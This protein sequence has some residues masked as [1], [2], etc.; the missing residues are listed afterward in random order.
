MAEK[1]VDTKE[2]LLAQSYDR[3]LS[4]NANAGSGK[5]T[6]LQKRFVALLLDNNLKV[7]PR[8]LVA[9][10]F[11]RKAAAEI[12]A[13]IAKSIEEIIQDSLISKTQHTK[14]IRIRE[15]LNSA[16]ISTIHSFC[17]SLIRDFPIES[18]VP[19]NF[20]ELS[21]AEKIGIMKD[22]ITDT[23]TDYLTSNDDNTEMLKLL[24]SAFGKKKVESMIKII[25]Y[26]RDVLPKI[27]LFYETHTDEEI[28]QIAVL[29]FLKYLSDNY[30]DTLSEVYRIFGTLSKLNLSR[31]QLTLIIAFRNIIN[32]VINLLNN[33]D[34]NINYEDCFNFNLSE[35]CDELNK[36][37]IL[38]Q[39]YLLNSPTFK[40]ILND[41]LFIYNAELENLQE[42]IK[43]LSC[44]DKIN[45]QTD[46]ISYARFLFDLT[47][48]VNEI[49]EYK[50]QE[51]G[52]LDFD[53][54]LIKAQD[55]LQNK[56]VAEKISKRF[57]FMM[58]DEFQDT[59]EIQYKIIKSLVPQLLDN[60]LSEQINL[61]IVGDPKQ[62][63][64]G[65]RNA[66]VRVFK[67]ATEDIRNCNQSLIQNT[68]L[69]KEINTA[70]GCISVEDAVQSQ[71]E[72]GLTVSFRHLPVITA[73]TNLICGNVMNR[74]D[75][76][77]DVEYS[78]LVCSKRIPELNNFLCSPNLPGNLEEDQFGSVR[79]LVCEK[80]DKEKKD[81]RISEAELLAIYI[82][83]FTATSQYKFSDI[84][85]LS[86]A[87]TKFNE[88][89]NAFQKYN[90]PYVLHSGKGFYQAQEVIDMIS[91][92]KFLHNPGD[93]LSI[94][95]ALRS[96]YFGLTDAQILQISSL[97]QKSLFEK[98]EYIVKNGHSTETVIIRS[99]EIISK[100]LSY[101]TRLS[102]SHLIAQTVE[103]CGWF[104]TSASSSG[105]AQVTANLLKLKQF[106]SDF[107]KRGFKTLFDFVEEVNLISK[108]EITESEAAF[109]TD[110]NAVNFLTIHAAK[111]LEFPVVA[112]FNNNTG[113]N[114]GDSFVIDE[115]LGLSFN[116]P[117]YNQELQIYQEIDTP[118]F[119]FAK[120]KNILKEKAELKRLLYVA[121][122]RAKEHL[123]IT[124]DLNSTKH[125][126]SLFE[127]ILQGLLI[128][129]GLLQA[130]EMQFLFDLQIYLDGTIDTHMI[131]FKIDIIN[132]IELA[133]TDI[134]SHTIQQPFPELLMD[135]IKSEISNDMFSASRIIK[136]REDR[137]A[138]FSRYVLG[139]D[140][141]FTL[142]QA[143]DDMSKF[144]ID[145]SQ[146]TIDE[147]ILRQAQ[148]DLDEGRL[149]AADRRQDLI[150]N[151]QFLITNEKDSISSAE[152]GTIIHF[153]MENIS[154][155]C[156]E[157]IINKNVLNDL[158]EES[159][160]IIRKELNNE[161][162]DRI[163]QEISNMV[164]T[165]L[166]KKNINEIISSKH[167]AEYNIPI[168]NDFLNA[169]IDLLFEKDSVYEVWDWKS[170]IAASK[171]DIIEFAKY[172]EFQ[173]KVYAYLV[174]LLQP[175]CRTYKS[176][177]LF[178]K[179]AKPNAIND[180]WTYEFIWTKEE[181]QSFK[182]ELENDIIQI[183]SA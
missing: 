87:R 40:K 147:T 119:F 84:A 134:S 92:L 141:D 133:S 23:L 175:E 68:R 10:T 148:D 61:F 5:T 123:I 28:N 163:I 101:S 144:T 80:V 115:G 16:H 158:L 110:D 152:E 161:F 12:F 172:Y 36:Q 127:L 72:M 180:D 49:I 69:S 162:K 4:V 143:Q 176:R 95:A 140:D 33:R 32:D 27:Q 183:K 38:T 166:I 14:L 77:F 150:T 18:S 74:K 42:L 6:V 94:T 154:K 88:L 60:S 107:E 173:M 145:N 167:E 98:L 57:R 165:E 46:L 178:T 97:K 55:M 20:S 31:E 137:D 179:L 151:K 103:L 156:S 34:N 128:E 44:L 93:D 117:V 86:R 131:N 24:I 114:N 108:E 39:K 50:K 174:M 105:R 83:N 171:D 25:L 153:I 51:A 149:Q 138:Y 78:N 43:V 111:G 182:T 85:V 157:E 109:I 15:R 89:S 181:L 13:K 67:K 73:F 41:D 177:L 47:K 48:Q 2:Q 75:S 53:D 30:A 96:P 132:E 29:E 70:K 104:G 58:V 129:Q 71:G 146:L 59:N 126:N 130:G 56:D 118:L 8:E 164:S 76:E 106:A 66:D 122:T 64:Y 169:K 112:L 142:R 17:S 121:L 26:K 81:E 3:H 139:F 11:T 7:E 159:S 21:E 45:H 113:R 63:I 160:L 170:N 22:A 9:I 37:K 90:I 116:T 35:L 1:F 136:F 62:S 155:W 125:K 65:F 19:P 100:L 102:I 91:V 82:K 52:G 99:Y 168:L 135:D 124:A 79:I 120:N 54:I